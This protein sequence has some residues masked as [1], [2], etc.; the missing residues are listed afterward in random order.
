LVVSEEWLHL[1][2]AVEPF[3]QSLNCRQ[4][5]ERSRIANCDH[6][7]RC[8]HFRFRGSRTGQDPQAEPCKPGHVNHAPLVVCITRV[9]NGSTWAALH[10]L[11]EPLLCNVSR[12]LPGV[13]C[14]GA[15]S[16]WV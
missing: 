11:D 3:D 10:H 15:R 14:P 5:S 16:V 4:V 9:N 1:H 7:A 12:T 8:S 6:L 2:I 13:I